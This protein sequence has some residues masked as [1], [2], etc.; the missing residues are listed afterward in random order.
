MSSFV[1]FKQLCN[2]RTSATTSTRQVMFKMS[3]HSEFGTVSYLDQPGRLFN[4]K[5]NK[6]ARP[7]SFC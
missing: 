4:S 3:S 1:Y 6:S 5:N 2:D 7:G